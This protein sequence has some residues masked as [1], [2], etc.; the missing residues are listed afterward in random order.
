M[1]FKVLYIFV[2]EIVKI[3]TGSA[4]ENLKLCTIV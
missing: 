3:K 2:V 4:E 1:I